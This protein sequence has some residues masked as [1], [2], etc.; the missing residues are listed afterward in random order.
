VVKQLDSVTAELAQVR[1]TLADVVQAISYFTILLIYSGHLLFAC[2]AL[3]LPSVPAGEARVA[4]RTV[5]KRANGVQGHGPS[6]A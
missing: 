2:F 5:P 6:V 1:F 3:M 4:N